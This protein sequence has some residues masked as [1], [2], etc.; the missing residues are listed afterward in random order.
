MQTLLIRLLNSEGW[1]QLVNARYRQH[2]QLDLLP[3]QK[4][5]HHFGDIFSKLFYNTSSVTLSFPSAT[6]LTPHT[7]LAS[8]LIFLELRRIIPLVP[9]I[10]FAFCP[11]QLV[12]K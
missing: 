6:I 8:K 10:T 1:F 9:L 4:H 11:K 3:I 2:N 5:T 12:E 7:L